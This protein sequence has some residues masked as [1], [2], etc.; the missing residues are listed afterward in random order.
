DD[1]QLVGYSREVWKQVRNPEAAFAA[2]FEIP[3]GFAQQADLPEENIR[4]LGKRGRLAMQFKKPWLV[5]K[6]VNLTHRAAQAEVNSSFCL[7]RKVRTRVPGFARH[8][9]R[10]DHAIPHQQTC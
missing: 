4:S 1:G 2:L 8:D 7:G 10:A 3:I 6:R 5:I 9:G